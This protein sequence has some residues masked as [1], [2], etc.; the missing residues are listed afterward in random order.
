MTEQGWGWRLGL[1]NKGPREHWVNKGRI[2][3]DLGLGGDYAPLVTQWL[4]WL[5]LVTQMLHKGKFYCM[6]INDSNF[7]KR[8]LCFKIFKT[9]FRKTICALSREGAVL[10]RTVL[11]V[12]NYRGRQTSLVPLKGQSS[13][14][15]RG[16]ENI[17]PGNSGSIS[18][19][20][21]H[22]LDLTEFNLSLFILFST[23]YKEYIKPNISIYDLQNLLE[24][25][26]F[27]CLFVWAV[28][29]GIPWSSSW[30]LCS[31]GCPWMLWLRLAL[32]PYF[33]VPEYRYM[34]PCLAHFSISKSCN[35]VT[36]CQKLNDSCFTLSCPDNDQCWTGEFWFVRLREPDSFTQS[37][38]TVL[39]ICEMGKNAMSLE[40]IQVYGSGGLQKSRFCSLLVIP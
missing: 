40:Y 30:P 35:V 27:F 16:K 31:R 10:L 22:S 8:K 12:T 21:V 13:L 29:S 17:Q 20:R 3:L 1:D 18:E 25:W 24:F 4:L 11:H 33:S 36:Y 14:S 7:K 15:I 37:L 23:N 9:S 38:C 2:L 32:N 34:P 5:P 26:P 39:L 6:W 28:W 19:R